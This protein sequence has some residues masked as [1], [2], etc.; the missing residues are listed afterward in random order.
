MASTASSIEA[1][2]SM[3]EKMQPLENSA[4]EGAKRNNR[5]RSKSTE[6]L[7][8]SEYQPDTME[9]TADAEDVIAES[10]EGSP[11]RGQPAPAEEEPKWRDGVTVKEYSNK[12]EVVI[13]KQQLKDGDAAMIVN[14]LAENVV[15]KLTLSENQLGDKAAEE[16]AK[17]LA[18]NTS[19][20]YITLAKNSI[21]DKGAGHLATA[22]KA[23]TK[24]QSFYMN[25]NLLT[26]DGKRKLKDANAARGTPLED[27][28]AGLVL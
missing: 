18:K 17:G 2:F 21:G 5:R 22:L 13:S 27:S 28:L 16:I 20:T 9:T 14:L 11:H 8:T 1:A 25:N 15:T 4:T 24:L 10:H 12:T 3:N 26:D 23:N 7:Q 19:L 6:L